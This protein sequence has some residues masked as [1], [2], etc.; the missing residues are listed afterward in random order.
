[1]SPSPQELRAQVEAAKARYKSE[2]QKYREQRDLRKKEKDRQMGGGE[3]WVSFIFSSAHGL[4]MNSSYRRSVENSDVLHQV[5]KRPETPSEMGQSI[6]TDEPMTQI[7]SNARGTFPQLEMFSVP[8]RHHT[9]SGPRRTIPID[10]PSREVHRICRR[11]ADVSS[12][13]DLDIMHG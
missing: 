13:L 7:V 5:P 6:A 2:K 9:Y 3:L 1:V 4:L 8:R 12:S 10:G 11:L